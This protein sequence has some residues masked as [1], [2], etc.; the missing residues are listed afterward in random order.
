MEILHSIYD[1]LGYWSWI[2]LGLM[3]F[4]LEAL[5]PGVYL[6]WFGMAALVIGAVVA[7]LTMFGATAAFSF[8]WQL[9]AF[10]LLAVV[11][12]FAAKRFARS[13]PGSDSPDINLPGAQFIGRIVIVEDPISQGR[14]KVR[15]GDTLW[16]AEGEDAPRGA[17]VVVT[18]VHGTALVVTADT[19]EA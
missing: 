14:G 10:A 17:K 1:S 8:E 15:A 5:I 7:L 6:L 13:A 2:L 9:V 11:M 19:S 12:V 18:G 4:V 3:L 16:L